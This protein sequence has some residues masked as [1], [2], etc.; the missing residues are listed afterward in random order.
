MT[1]QQ[2]AEAVAKAMWAQDGASKWVGMELVSVGEGTATLALTVA[3]QHCN[4]HGFCH[5][6]VTFTL[7]DSAFAY[8]C[9]SRNQSTVAQHNSI[10][11]TAAGRLGDRLTATATEVALPGRSGIYDV[12]V[13]NQDGTVIAQFRG[14]SRAIRG[15]F[16]PQD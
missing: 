15:S 3:P 8:A 2:T 1:P 4:G 10:T 16:L 7:A 14:L 13:T 9:N 11:Y 5:G 6:G 12:S